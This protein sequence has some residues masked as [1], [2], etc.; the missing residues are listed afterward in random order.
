M[1]HLERREFETAL[2]L[3]DRRFC[4][5]ASQLVAAMPDFA[6]NVQN[7]ASML[8]RLEPRGVAVGDRRVELADKAKARIGDWLSPFTLPH[9]TMA[10]A[11]AGR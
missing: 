5:L 11:S 1:F 7:A 8:F 6:T 3:Y 10:L 2:D 9:R 4:D